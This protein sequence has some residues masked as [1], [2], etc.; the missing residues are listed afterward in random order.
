[1]I[2]RQ[3]LWTLV[4]CCS[5]HYVYSG[6]DFDG[7]ANSWGASETSEGFVN[8]WGLPETSEGQNQWV[9]FE[10][11]APGNQPDGFTSDQYPPQE[12]GLALLPEDQDG[13]PKK[14]Q[15]LSQGLIYPCPCLWGDCSTLG[16]LYNDPT[17]LWNHLEQTHFKNQIR[18]HNCKWAGCNQFKVPNRD[19]KDALMN[20]IASDH[21]GFR[22]YKCREKC[23]HAFYS[24]K[25]RRNHEIVCAKNNN[26]QR[27]PRKSRQTQQPATASK[28]HQPSFPEANAFAGNPDNFI[29]N[30]HTMVAYANSMIRDAQS[31]LFAARPDLNPLYAQT[32]VNNFPLPY[33]Q[34]FPNQ[35]YSYPGLALGGLPH[36]AVGQEWLRNPVLPMEQQYYQ[37]MMPTQPVYS[38]ELP[39]E[40]NTQERIETQA[41]QR[42]V[43]FSCGVAG[44]EKTFADKA[45]LKDHIRFEHILRCCWDDCNEGPFALESAW[46]NHVKRHAE[47]GSN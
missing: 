4:A 27:R 23:D 11:N 33:E 2:F 14:R 22:P 42:P 17:Q 38:Q 45:L 43:I 7:S 21:I 8:S 16:V 3:M 32:I 36:Q 26:T 20:H 34:P 13:P 47:K 30:A 29:A 31:M 1:M 44:C 9:N 37:A 15:R 19:K 25:D 24:G 35:A 41:Q 6:G 28:N 12:D 40:I 46:L 10:N 18:N 5:C 39:V